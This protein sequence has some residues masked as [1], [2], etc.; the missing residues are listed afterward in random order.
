MTAK[1]T[2][3]IATTMIHKVTRPV[4]TGVIPITTRNPKTRPRARIMRPFA[5][6][7]VYICNECVAA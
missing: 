2:A 6:P 7:G 1:M 4:L 3:A 5:G